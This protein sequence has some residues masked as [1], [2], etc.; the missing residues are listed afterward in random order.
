MRTEFKGDILLLRDLEDTIRATKKYTKGAFSKSP[1][2][3]PVLQG[4]QGQFPSRVLT[5]YYEVYPDMEIGWDMR[6]ADF[7]AWVWGDVTHIDVT[8]LYNYKDNRAKVTIRGG[9][10]AVRELR[11]GIPGFSALLDTILKDN[12]Q[13]GVKATSTPGKQSIGGERTK[14]PLKALRRQSRGNAPT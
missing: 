6:A 14:D 3:P 11:A 13:R 8:F 5:E 10:E 1:K 9:K 12:N 4:N 2:H 7:W